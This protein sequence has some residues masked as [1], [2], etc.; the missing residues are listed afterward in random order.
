MDDDLE[1]VVELLLVLVLVVVE[2]DLAFH[3]DHVE[4]EEVNDEVEEDGVV[5]GVVVLV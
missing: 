1:V 2:D 3:V 4:V 5:V